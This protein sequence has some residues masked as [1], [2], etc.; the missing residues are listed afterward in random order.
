MTQHWCVSEYAK[1]AFRIYWL[2]LLIGLNLFYR[3]FTCFTTQQRK[4]NLGEEI[5]H[6]MEI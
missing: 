3:T 1:F 4:A 6:S 5:L 2:I